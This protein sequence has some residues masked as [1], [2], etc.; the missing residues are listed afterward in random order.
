VAFRAVR[1]ATQVAVNDREQVL[2]ATRELVTAV[3]EAN[4]LSSKDVISMLFTATR[5]L[6]AAPPALAARQLGLHD[7]ALL[8]AQ[9]MFVDGSMPR[10]VRV[11]AHIDTD[12]EQ[13]SNVYLHGTEVLRADIPGFPGPVG[14]E[15]ATRS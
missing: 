12:R 11:M 14:S 5:D 8:C 15:P 2:A 6:T 9:E 7:V 13:V 3:L 10:V 4:D 1:G